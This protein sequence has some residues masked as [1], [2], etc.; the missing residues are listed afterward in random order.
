VIAIHI[1]KKHSYFVLD[2]RRLQICRNDNS[3]QWTIKLEGIHSHTKRNALAYNP[4]QY[5]FLERGKYMVS[6]MH[7]DNSLKLHH[8]KNGELLKSVIWHNDMVSV[9]WCGSEVLVVGSADSTISV[10]RAPTSPFDIQ[11][12]LRLY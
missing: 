9:V 3:K 10:W 11:E 4:S 8:T 6:G 5:G 7:W 2:D 1:E 12:F